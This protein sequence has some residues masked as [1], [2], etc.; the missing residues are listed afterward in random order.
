M[1][2]PLLGKVD[3]STWSVGDVATGTRGQKSA[4]VFAESKPCPHLQLCTTQAAMHC[5]FGASAY[6]DDGTATRLNMELDLSDEQ[7]LHLGKLDDWARARAKDLNLKGEYRPCVTTDKHG[8]R[9]T[10]VKVST[11][12]VHAARFWDSV[13][14]P[15]GSAKDL[16]L[17]GALVTPVVACTKM[18]VMAGQF[19]LCLELRHGVVSLVSQECPEMV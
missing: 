4:P 19:G 9:R 15:L 10:R 12:G 13:R 1:A 6:N 18:W 3:F 17:Q 7:C 2:F 8:H 5:P 14:T 16:A 11:T